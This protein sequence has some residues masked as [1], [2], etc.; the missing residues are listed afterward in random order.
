MQVSENVKNNIKKDRKNLVLCGTGGRL[1]L[2]EDFR[3]ST[4]V[5]SGS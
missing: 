5:S 1:L 3:N 4:A 2:S